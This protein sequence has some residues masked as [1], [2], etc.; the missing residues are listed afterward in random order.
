M[1]ESKSTGTSAGMAGTATNA[2]PINATPAATS[3]NQ[4]L[5]DFLKNFGKGIGGI[6]AKMERPVDTVGFP[7]IEKKPSIKPFKYDPLTIRR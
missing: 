3:E 1:G 4:V 7:E 5:S 6:N 2:T